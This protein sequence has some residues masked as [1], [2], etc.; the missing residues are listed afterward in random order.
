MDPLTR[1]FYDRDAPA[2]ARDLVGRLLVREG[3]GIRLV[4][5]VVETEAYGDDDP[6]S[7]AFRGP[8]RRNASMFGPPGHAYVYISHG[9]H[10]CLNAV[11]RAPTAVLIRSLQPL[12]GAEH[13]ARRR[14]IDDVRLLCAGPGRLCQAMGIGTGDDGADLTIGHGLWFAGG[15][16]SVDV[17]A[18]PRVG[19]STATERPWR[20]VE[21]GS[22]FASRPAL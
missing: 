1:D 5:K 20:F 19:I 7:H 13:M 11:A 15:P 3:D 16:P 17:V 9:I 8:T 4:G 12:E 21:R 18:T 14:A 10:H 22:R 2:V 6:A